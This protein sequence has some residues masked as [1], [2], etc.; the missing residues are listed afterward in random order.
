MTSHSRARFF[1]LAILSLVLGVTLSAC[2]GGGIAQDDVDAIREQLEVVEQRLDDVYG[3]LVSMQGEI[4]DDAPSTVIEAQQELDDTLAILADVIAELAPPPPPPPP[5][6]DP[7][8][9]AAP[10]SPAF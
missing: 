5:E 6:A 3:M 10:G 8:A 2:G 7:M 4:G 9:P 1:V